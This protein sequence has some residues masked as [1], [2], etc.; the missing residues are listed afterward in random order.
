MGDFVVVSPAHHGPL[1]IKSALLAAALVVLFFAGQPVAKV[2]IIGG[3]LLLFNRRLKAD[4]VY[5]EIDWPLLVM[6][7]GTLGAARGLRLN[8]VHQLL[9]HPVNHG[10]A[11]ARL[12][13]YRSA[14]AHCCGPAGTGAAILGGVASAGAAAMAGVVG[15]AAG[16]RVAL[17]PG[18]P[19]R[20][21]TNEPSSLPGFSLSSLV[22]CI[23]LL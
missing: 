16:R 19:A 14:T 21:H 11:G 12:R 20:S 8:K 15:P 1:V 23:A 17:A 6:I 13:A 7:V 5:R 3:A 9:A 2:A 4:K 22:R 18:V 10:C